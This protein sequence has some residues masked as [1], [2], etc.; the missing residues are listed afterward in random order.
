LKKSPSKFLIPMAYAST[1][2]G[3]MTLIGTSTT[4]LASSVWSGMGNDPFTMFL[5]TDI[6]VAVF[7][8]GALYLALVGY[9]L[10]PDRAPV[11]EG[12]PY[13]LRPFLCEI[14]VQEESPLIGQRVPDSNLKLRYDIDVVRLIRG[15]SA[16]EQ[17]LAT[18]EIQRGDILIIR[19]SRE[20]ILKVREE[21][22]LELL[23]EVT[24]WL[25]QQ[26]DETMLAQAIIAP[27]SVLEGSNL[28]EVRFRH[29]FNA[30][31]LAVRKRERF[32]ISRIS[33][34][35]LD[36]GDELPDFIVPQEIE[37]EPF[38]KEKI[39]IILTIFAL[40]VGLAAFNVFPIVVTALAGV[41]AMVATGCLKVHE[42]QE[43]IRWDVV[44]LLAGLIP[45]GIAFQK[46]GAAALLGNKIAIVS[47]DWPPLAL[48]ALLY[49][50]TMVLTEIMSNNA[51][52]VL[53]IPVAVSI[54]NA[55]GMDPFS[56]VVVVT[57]AATLA[58]MTPVGYQTHLMVYGPGSYRFID[59]LKVG[60]PLNLIGMAV[61]LA[62]IHFRWGFAPV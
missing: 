62:M 40:V 56:L 22:G 39:P 11:D 51:T 32:F 57:F 29:R 53:M 20:E 25:D 13:D 21:E 30:V 43:A 48:A 2:G 60:G 5:F 58:F 34:L 42:F 18:V 17:P 27:G 46:T 15:E 28:Q 44:F 16:Y 45:L 37:L 38:R 35:R 49:V 19:A 12:R 8:A 3:M 31:A 41:F 4:I 7:L 9:H 52:I 10:L 26:G 33:R 61:T 24:H 14:V 36:A 47:A 54:A 23:P 6:G 50:V 55:T 59:F 1:L